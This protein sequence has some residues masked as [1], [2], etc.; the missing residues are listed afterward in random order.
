MDSQQSGVQGTGG[1]RRYMFNEK[2]DSPRQCSDTKKCICESGAEYCPIKGKALCGS[3]GKCKFPDNCKHIEGQL[4][5][6]FCRCEGQLANNFCRCAPDTRDPTSEP[7]SSAYNPCPAIHP[8]L[9]KYSTGDLYWCYEKAGNVGPCR[10]LYSGLPA[11][12]DGSW[13]TNQNDCV[14]TKLAVDAGKGAPLFEHC[15]TDR[16]YCNPVANGQLRC[17]A[18]P[19]CDTYKIKTSG[20]CTDEEGWDYITTSD[21]PTDLEKELLMAECR[22]AKEMLYPSS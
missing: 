15:S 3:D 1:K 13:G 11:P 4:A 21:T 8:Y 19:M 2:F 7:D 16:P 18:N 10:M 14:L 6:N 20:R 12:L 5:N 9:E 22:T 17:T